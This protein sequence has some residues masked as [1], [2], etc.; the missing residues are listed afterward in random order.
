[1]VRSL[2]NFPEP[3]T[4]KIA[5]RA[6][7]SRSAYNSTQPLVGF[8]IGLEVRQ[9]HIV[10]AVGQQR[11]AQRRKHA[12]LIAAE[13]VGEDQIQRGAGLRLIVVVPVRVVP[14]A[15]ARHLFRR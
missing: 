9:V 14:A 11:V 13:V 10:V 2:E 7:A 1:M 6:Q 12:G 8:E 4:F 5:L 3:A 15:A